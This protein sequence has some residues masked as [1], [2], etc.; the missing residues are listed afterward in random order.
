[1]VL[2]EELHPDDLASVA[3]SVTDRSVRRGYIHLLERVAE[4]GIRW[5]PPQLQAECLDHDAVVAD[6]ETLQ[7][8]QTLAVTH[9][10]E[11]GHQQQMQ[12]RKPNPGPRMRIWDRPEVADWIEIG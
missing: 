2:F 5:R 3:R 7:I 11:Q 10:S 9:D 1:M 4:R 8:L 12:G 6:S